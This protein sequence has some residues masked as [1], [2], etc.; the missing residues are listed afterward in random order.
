MVTKHQ[1]FQ[2]F[3]KA[4]FEKVILRP[5][6]KA[7][8]DFSDEAC[9]L[10]LVSG[11][12][13]VETQRGPIEM[14]AEEGVALRCGTYVNNYFENKDFEYCEAVAVHFYPEVLKWLY[15]KEFPN[16]LK[17]V[18]KIKP[19]SNQHIPGSTV[20][21]SYIEN[22][23]FYFDNPDLVSEELLKLK[24]KEIIL[25][26]AKT[27][28]RNAIETLVASMFTADEVN[29]KDIIENNLYQNLSLED[30]SR[31]CNLSLSSFKREFSKY[32][33]TSPAK[34]IRQRKLQKAASLLQ[35]TELRISD[36]AFD[37]G[38]N[39]LAHF[40]KTFQKKYGVSP[41]EYRLNQNNKSLS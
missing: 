39:D 8:G 26:L 16:F 29:F 19:L 14:N 41:S 20:L 32:Y 33:N 3:G 7:I 38:F 9:F 5:P 13:T 27:D 31:L 4:A 28:Q 12:S 23:Q 37:S 34:Y 35:V 11:K 30:L 10:Y 21:K 1:Q 40:S 6:F 24:M 25:L 36:V 18:K 15:D 2:L 17:E 22:L